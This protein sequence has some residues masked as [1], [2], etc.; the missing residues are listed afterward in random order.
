[1]ASDI[2]GLKDKLWA[3]CRAY[4]RAK[5]GDRCFTCGR[6]GLTGANQHTGHFIPSGSCGAT[7]R[8]HPNN[9]RIQCYNC[10]INLGGNGAEYY[11]EMERTLGKKKVEALFQLKNK[12]IKADE[13]FYKQMIE[14][15]KEAI[16]TGKEKKIIKFLES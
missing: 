15:Y 16:V 8:Y 14:L 4:F 1:M 5:Y 6:T 3:Q 11:R 10:N 7:L 13:L 9:L 12:S 2:K